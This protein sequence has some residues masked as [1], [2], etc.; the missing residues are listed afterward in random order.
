MSHAMHNRFSTVRD[1]WDEEVKE[2]VRQEF[3]KD[4]TDK[5][6]MSKLN[7]FSILTYINEHK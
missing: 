6:D 5:L 2:L 4:V 7:L 1:A 3:P